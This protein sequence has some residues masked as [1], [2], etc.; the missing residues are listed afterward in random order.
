MNCS[1]CQGSIP[2]SSG[3]CKV[4]GREDSS[5]LLANYTKLKKE[6]DD[7][8]CKNI[9]GHPE[10]E[11][12]CESFY[13]DMKTIFHP[14]D[15]KYLDLLEM[16]FEQRLAKEN[17]RGS[18]SLALEILEHYYQHYPKFDINTGLMELK[19]A[20]LLAFL[21]SLEEAEK[22][23]E[24]AKDILVVTHGPSHPLVAGALKQLKQD[25]DM[26]RRELNDLRNTSKLKISSSWAKSG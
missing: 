21:D 4:C 11:E 22:H 6:F 19:T 25:I 14:W 1:T 8:V 18:M 7:H 2:I 20:K 5:S 3:I 16:L 17:F 15:K 26:G 13:E 10:P 12:D 9:N 24:K 23:L